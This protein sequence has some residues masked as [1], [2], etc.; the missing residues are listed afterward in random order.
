MRKIVV[1][2]SGA[3][4]S[5]L[6]KELASRGHDVTVL[7][8]GRYHRLGS[9]MEAMKFYPRSGWRLTPGEVSEGDVELLRT[10]MAGGSTMVT[11]ANALRALEDELRSVGLNLEEEFAE[12]EEEMGVK[13]MPE[14]MM[15]ERTVLLMHA[16]ERLGYDVKPMPK[17]V[18]FTRC[19]SCGM[20]VTGCAYGAKWTAQNY[21]AEARKSGARIVL[22]SEVRRVIHSG[23]MVRGLEVRG[24]SG[25]YELETD[26]V[27]LAAGGLGTPRILLRSGIEAGQ[28]L[29]AD[30]FVNTYGIVEGVSWGEEMGMATLI[31]EFAQEGF[32]LS[33]I[34]DTKMHMLLYLPMLKKGLAF[35]RDR[36]LGIMTKIR[37]E[38]SGRVFEDG[39]RKPVTVEDRRRIEK[40]VEVSR[41]ILIEAGARESSIYTTRVRGAHL[42]GTAPIGGVVNRDLETEIE[43]LFVGDA[44]AFPSSPG[45]PPVLTI[46]ALAKRLS[47]LVGEMAG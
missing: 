34:L 22:N 43:G 9:E 24:P 2:G 37:D 19:S 32:I 1:V 38:S 18:D 40:G 42:G 47:R 11:L 12:A 36:L 30:L 4:G 3:G 21:L 10:L 23:G 20:C 44:S 25:S 16:S 8:R 27:V 35:K 28:G 14:E 5:T 15:G 6:A 17:S 29:F 41:E 13:P 39:V 7:E 46:V 26:L 45:E 33:P 31:D